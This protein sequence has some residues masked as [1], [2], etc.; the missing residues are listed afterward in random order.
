LLSWV[1]D[2]LQFDYKAVLLSTDSKEIP[3]V[4]EAIGAEIVPAHLEINQVNL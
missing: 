4:A 3:V 2:R 1:A